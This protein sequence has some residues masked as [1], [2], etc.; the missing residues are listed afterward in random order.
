MQ[1]S[2]YLRRCPD[3]GL[4]FAAST[5]FEVARFRRKGHMCDREAANK[6]KAVDKLT[7]ESLHRHTGLGAIIHVQQEQSA[8][9]AG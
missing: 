3:G 2:G 8:V 4:F 1:L 7:H 6:R 9:V 5:D